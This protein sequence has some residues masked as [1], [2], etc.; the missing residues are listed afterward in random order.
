[1]CT[2]F[3]TFV[4]ANV[5]F[6]ILPFIDVF[7]DAILANKDNYLEILAIAQIVAFA[8]TVPWNKFEEAPR[9]RIHNVQIN[10]DAYCHIPWQHSPVRLPDGPPNNNEEWNLITGTPEVNYSTLNEPLK[11][12]S[13]LSK[14]EVLLTDDLRIPVVYHRELICS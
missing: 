2:Q 8:V 12:F 5:L 10:V 9:G 7:G 3:S 1:M 14:Q 6:V 11:Y 4:V 13:N